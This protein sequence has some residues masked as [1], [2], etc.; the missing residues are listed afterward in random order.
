VCTVQGSSGQRSR[1]G[2]NPLFRAQA[3]TRGRQIFVVGDGEMASYLVSRRVVEAGVKDW[4]FLDAAL[5][6]LGATRMESTS[7][8]RINRRRYVSDEND[9]L[10]S[11]RHLGIRQRH[12]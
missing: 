8:R 10:P 4:H 3:W 1:F 11:F 12:S 7:D 5:C 2:Y 6:S 9:T